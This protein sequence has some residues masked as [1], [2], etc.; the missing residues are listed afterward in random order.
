MQLFFFGDFG[1]FSADNISF[2]CKVID[3]GVGEYHDNLRRSEGTMSCDVDCRSPTVGGNS[4]VCDESDI[5]V[6]EQAL[7]LISC[8]IV[9][10]AH[11]AAVRPKALD[12]QM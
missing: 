6:R 8:L 9:P 2:T 7:Q 4:R 3:V 1:P 10:L 5:G 11:T 12:Q